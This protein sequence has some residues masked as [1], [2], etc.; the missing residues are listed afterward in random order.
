MHEATTEHRIELFD[1]PYET[2][3]LDM[4]STIDPVHI[5]GF[6]DAVQG[7]DSVPVFWAAIGRYA[8][9]L[10]LRVSHGDAIESERVAFA[11]LTRVDA[12]P[13]LGWLDTSMGGQPG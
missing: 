3:R 2:L 5:G 6:A 9:A 8:G 4:P 12:P 10:G 1:A 13:D 7:A 11:T